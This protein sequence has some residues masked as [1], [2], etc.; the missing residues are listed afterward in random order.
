MGSSPPTRQAAGTF[1]YGSTRD[2]VRRLTV[3]LADGSVLDLT[4]REAR[5][6][7]DGHFEIVS[8][9]YT[10]RVPVPTYEM[11][12]VPKRSAGY[13]AAT[14]MDLVDLF[15]GSEGMLGVVTEITFAIVPRCPSTCLVWIPVPSEA[16]AVALVSWP[17]CEPKRS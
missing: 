12:A 5:A 11:P 14:E 6:H 9:V 4:R 13:F 10:R 7:P 1:K 17:R 8:D 15:V 16:E 3:V 2:R